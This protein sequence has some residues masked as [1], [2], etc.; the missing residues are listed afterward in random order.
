M[1]P[2]LGLSAAAVV[3][4]I[5]VELFFVVVIVVEMITVFILSYKKK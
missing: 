3:L 2:S 1:P 4:N 5:K